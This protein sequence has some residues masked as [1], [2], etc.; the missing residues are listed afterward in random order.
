MSHTKRH[1]KEMAKSGSMCV[2]SVSHAGEPSGGYGFIF[3]LLSSD[4]ENVYISSKQNNHIS[5]FCKKGT[6]KSLFGV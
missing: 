5:D 6:L 1:T 4:L 2:C 3:V